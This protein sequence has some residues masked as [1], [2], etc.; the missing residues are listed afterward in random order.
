MSW[1]CTYSLLPPSSGLQVTDLSCSWQLKNAHQMP[2]SLV[3]LFNTPMLFFTRFEE[4]HSFCFHM[5][6]GKEAR[7][8]EEEQ[9]EAILWIPNPFNNC[10]LLW[11]EDT[12]L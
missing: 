2:P 3:C 7:E 10:R 1:C 6:S 11:I 9:N 4:T 5:Y 12:S 8:E